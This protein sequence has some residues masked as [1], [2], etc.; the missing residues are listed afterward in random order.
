MYEGRFSKIFPFFI[1][2]IIF[3]LN[4]TEPLYAIRSESHADANQAG[5]TEECRKVGLRSTPH[6][7]I[8][9]MM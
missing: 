2:E 5:V 6:L 4:K 1:K 9:V 7:K 3:A 8:Y